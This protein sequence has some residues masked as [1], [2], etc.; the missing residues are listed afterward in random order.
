MNHK[1]T[2]GHGITENFDEHIKKS[3]RGYDNLLKDVINLS[4]YFV[5]QN[6]TVVDVGCST[7][8]LLEGI[9]EKNLIKCSYVGVELEESFSASMTKTKERVNK[10]FPGTNLEF[11]Q[12]DI[13]NYNFKNCS[14]VTSIFTLQFLPVKDRASTIEKIYKG[15]NKGGCFI[16][17]EKIV[18]SDA[19]FQE[20]LTFNYYDYKS[21]HF[22]AEE[23]LNKEKKLRSMLKPNTWQ[24]INQMLID[25]GFKLVQ[26]FW[27]DH[28]FIGAVAIKEAND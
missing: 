10:A 8:K 27:M 25:A 22:T 2:F 21:T 11:L 3:I 1:F 28:M 7:G 12:N 19:R 20:M 13:R 16:F 6:T 23:I 18:C 17:A 9:I 4:Q 26:P 5:D 14:L 15:L 24:E